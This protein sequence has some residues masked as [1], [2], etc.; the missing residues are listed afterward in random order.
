MRGASVEFLHALP[1]VLVAVLARFFGKFF[2]H[3]VGEVAPK[4]GVWPLAH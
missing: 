4:N 3:D 2:R 1:P